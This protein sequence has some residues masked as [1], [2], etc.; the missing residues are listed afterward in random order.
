MKNRKR[1]FIILGI[2]LILL[3]IL[4]LLV[5]RYMPWHKL[6]KVPTSSEAAFV[7]QDP[8]RSL[9][10]NS[11]SFDF[12][13]DSTQEVPKGIYKGI[14]HS[15]NY[16]A[17]VFGNNSFSVS[18]VRTA[19]EIGLKNLNA[20]A[21]S[22]WVYA[23]PT[24][25]EVNGSLVFA[26][27]NSVGVNLCWKG[28]HFTGP[29][30]PREQWTKV[31][32]YY[33]LSDVRIRPDD[34]IQ[35]YFW[36]NSSTDLLVDDFYY[37]F[38]A[39]RERLGDS[40][41]A[42]MTKK[43]GYKPQFNYPPFQLM[44]LQKQDIG[45]GDGLFLVQNKKTQTGGITPAD[46]VISGNFITAPGALQSMLVIQPTGKP[47]LYHFCQTNSQFEE[48]ALDCPEDLYPLFQECT[49]LKGSFLPQP[50]DQL[51]VAGPG[52]MALLGFE[53]T[54]AP[55]TRSGSSGRLKILWRSDKPLLADVALKNERQL[56]SGDLDGD[57]I[58]ELLLFDKKGSWK[59]LKFVPSGPTSGNW[60][61]KATGEE[62]KIREWNRALVEFNATAAPYLSTYNNDLILT[63]FRELKSGK[64]SYTLLR[65]LPADGKFVKVFPDRNGSVGLTIGIDTL[66]LSDQLLPGHF[67]PG[68]PLSFFRYN[69][70]WRYDLKDIRFNY[71]TFQILSSIDFTGFVGDQNPKYYE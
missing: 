7:Q 2:A 6:M 44:I 61:E 28:V 39:P 24:D 71:S 54:S 45:N 15:G 70:D 20:V 63:I 35:L 33:D 50:G 25:N 43:E 66:K 65:F 55:C 16:S 17:K 30:I 32:A 19:G 48:I 21:I 12:E 57:R 13:V 52:G 40:T 34:K 9:A 29:M 8:M 59:L 26:V 51:F 68:K 62:H 5:I 41:R 22:A 36:N 1:L 53:T 64:K 60:K 42:D 56:T 3:T 18:V 11:L 38:G 67:Q 49:W 47:A 58:D 14:A 69:R 46:Q 37:V 10:P 31:S 4:A 27:N 23:F